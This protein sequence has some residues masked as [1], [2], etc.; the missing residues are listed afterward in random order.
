MQEVFNMPGKVILEVTK[1]SRQGEKYEYESAERLFIGRQEDCGIVMSENTV[2]RYH[3]LLDIQPPTVKLQDFGSL[4]G[5]FLN[6][7]K[8]GQRDRTQSWEAAKDEVHEEFNLHNGDVLRLGSLCELRCVIEAA[9]CC[10]VCGAALPKLIDSNETLPEGEEYSAPRY[11]ENGNRICEACWQVK[12]EEKKLAAAKMAEDEARRAEEAARLAAEKAEQERRLA[13]AAEAKRLAE[14]KKERERLEAERQREEARI[15]AEK[16]KAEEAAAAKAKR[17]AAEKAEAARLAAQ[18]AEQER[19]A[20]EKRRQEA[21]QLVAALA[22]KLNS[23]VQNAQK[24]CRGCG[25]MFTPKAADNNLCPDCLNDRA[26]LLNGIL[27]ALVGNDAQPEQL[28]PSFLEGYD[29]VCLLGK[30][31]MGEVWKVKERKTGKTYALKTMLPQVAADENS[32]KL[33]LREAGVCECLKHKNVVKAYKTGCANGVFYILMDLCEGGSVDSLMEKHGGKLPVELATYIILQALSGLDYVHNM[34][35]DVEIKA[36]LFKGTKEA[37]AK[38]VVHRDFKP[39]NIFLADKSDHPLAMVADFGMAK[40]FET[41]GMSRNTKSGQVMGTPVFMPRQQALNFKYA[42]PEV[43]VWAAAAS[44]YNMLTGQFPKNFRPGK[45]PWQIIVS[46]P[47]ESIRKRNSSIPPRLAAV[48]DKALVE[49]PELS[50]KSAADFRR[51][52]IKALSPEVY[53]YC[54]GVIK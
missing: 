36:G 25:K 6:E 22:G 27:A 47:A 28:T 32:K 24:K 3:C 45:N 29:K 5:T 41:A 12:Q 49:Q 52:I 33:F 31:G 7:Q 20:A 34:D 8:I 48:I 51:D 50:Y 30:G 13:E 53:A 26:Q 54:K 44:Y 1:G 19:L 14:E 10:P 16:K 42:K 4:N 15:A 38:G 35:I 40:A 17:I 37:S 2:S 21:E 9:E 23:P 46:E 18:K 43:D 11:D 39:G